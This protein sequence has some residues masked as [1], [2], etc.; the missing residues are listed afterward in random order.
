[1]SDR[2]RLG[3]VILRDDEET[4]ASEKLY[5]SRLG[6]NASPSRSS[7]TSR[8]GSASTSAV[9]CD[10]AHPG[11]VGRFQRQGASA[12]ALRSRLCAAH[13][14]RCGARRPAKTRVLPDVPRAA[15]LLRRRRACVR[16]MRVFF[17]VRRRRA[18]ALVRN[19]QVSLRFGSD[20]M[21]R[22]PP[23]AP[24]RWGPSATASGCEGSI[25]KGAG[26][27]CRAARACRGHRPLPAALR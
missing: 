11:D 7:I 16:A 20:P 27:A 3:V 14:S 24:L 10:S 8:I 19:A 25:P 1:M 26:G 22:M 6:A 9:R 23:Q 4:R 12:R 5:V 17:R 2:E 15:I 21:S 18:E 13:A